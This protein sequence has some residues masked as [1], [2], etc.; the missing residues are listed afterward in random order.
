MTTAPPL[1]L[2]SASPRRRRLLDMLGLAFTVEPSRIEE[3]L[4]DGEDPAGHVERLARE[5]GLAVASSRPEAL[6]IGG[7]T[8]V[9]VDHTPLGKPADEAEAVAMLLRLQGTVHRVET[10]VAVVAPGGRVESSVVGV[11]VW[12]RAFDR[13]TAEQYV[14]TGEPM[15]KAGAY[16][17]QGYG[18]TLVDRIDG[19]YFAVM[20]LP[21]ARLVSLLRRVGWNYTFHG[22]EAL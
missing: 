17:I 20:G 22:L 13:R 2:A 7:D 8:I 15:D 4:H 3:V 10:G 5:K 9:V 12:F 18:A 21:L 19:D 11:Q 1:V 14:S 6:V 16:G